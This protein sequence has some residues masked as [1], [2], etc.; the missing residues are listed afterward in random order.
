MLELLAGTG[1]GLSLDDFGAGYSSLCYLNVFPFDTLK[2]DRALVNT[3]SKSGSGS[4]ILRSIVALAHELGK[5][6]VAEG[7]ESEDD[8]GLLRTIGCEYAQGFFYGGPVSQREVLQSLK[9]LRKADRRLRRSTMFRIRNRPADDTGDE[10][11]AAESARPVA[12]PAR[13][14]AKSQPK[15]EPAAPPAMPQARLR[16]QP[17]PQ[18]RQSAAPPSNPQSARVAEAAA[19]LQAMFG[20]QNTAPPIPSV[21]FNGAAPERQALPPHMRPQ[22]PSG[23]SPI[24]SLLQQMRG[25]PSAEPQSFVQ[26]DQHH[27]AGHDAHANGHVGPRD[28]PAQSFNGHTPPPLGQTWSAGDAGEAGAASSSLPPPIAAALKPMTGEAIQTVTAAQLA[29]LPPAIARSLALLA[30]VPAAAE[31]PPM[32]IP[33]VDETEPPPRG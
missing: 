11:A 22:T 8:I 21:P 31:P 19:R 27:A 28:H 2:V 25:G 30:G 3:S 32:P 18:P 4:A 17:P 29:T 9:S 5:K 14:R 15:S 12:V 6:V 20:S 24:S 23:D 33:P 13:R 7:V 1:V 10:I 26:H 16:P